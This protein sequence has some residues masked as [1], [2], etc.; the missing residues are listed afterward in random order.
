MGQTNKKNDMTVEIDPVEVNGASL[1]KKDEEQLVYYLKLCFDQGCSR[2]EMVGRVTDDY[3]AN[4]KYKGFH[5]NNGEE[6]DLKRL[7][8]FVRAYY[9]AIERKYGTDD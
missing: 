7:Q 2:E 9:D 8:A 3:M 4:L 6:V 5:D 1:N